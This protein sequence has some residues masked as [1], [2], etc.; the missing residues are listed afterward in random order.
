MEVI[1]LNRFPAFFR[2]F[3]CFSWQSLFV[4]GSEISCHAMSIAAGHSV[5][6]GWYVGVG[7][8]AGGDANALFPGDPFF[9][10]FLLIL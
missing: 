7:G 2:A 6:R 5:L 9:F 3:S 1:P 4:F 10:Q 8:R